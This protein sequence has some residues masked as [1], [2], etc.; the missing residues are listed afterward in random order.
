VSSILD[1]Y[2]E[3]YAAAWADPPAS[4]IAAN[5]RYLAD[6]F[7][8]LDEAGNVQMDKASYIGFAQLLMASFDDFAAVISD[9]HAEGD[10]I[11][12]SSHFEGTHTG[13]LDLSALGMGVIPA[14]G[15]RIIWPEAS[16]RWKFKGGKIASIQANDDAGGVG[17]FLAALGVTP[18]PA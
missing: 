18:P 11:I 7:Q 8:T 10:S 4:V 5:Q 1:T 12:V 14:S 3:Y 2:N 9:A 6:D 15:K 16:T 13:D 17:P